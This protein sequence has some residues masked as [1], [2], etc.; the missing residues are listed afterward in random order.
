MSRSVM[1]KLE[2]VLSTLWYFNY[3]MI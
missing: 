1:F 2:L 3:C